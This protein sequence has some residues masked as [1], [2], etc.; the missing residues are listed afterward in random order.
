M[1]RSDDSAFRRRQTIGLVILAL[2]V[3]LFAALRAGW[4]AVFLAGWWRLW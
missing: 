2:A 3:L 1:I 4:H